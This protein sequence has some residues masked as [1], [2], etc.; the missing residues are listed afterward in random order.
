MSN[1]IRVTRRQGGSARITQ[2]RSFV[3][4]GP[5]EVAALIEQ[6]TAIQN[7]VWQPIPRAETEQRIE[8]T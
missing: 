5:A 4:A 2:G 7:N 8:R 3:L 6:L 1:E